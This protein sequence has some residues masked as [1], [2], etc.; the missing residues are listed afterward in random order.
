MLK[1]LFKQLKNRYLNLRYIRPNLTTS[2]SR[3]RYGNV[4]VINADGIG[5]WFVN[6]DNPTDNRLTVKINGKTVGTVKPSFPRSDINALLGKP[7]NGGFFVSWG[8]LKIDSDLLKAKRW[9]VQIVHRNKPLAGSRVLTGGVLKEIKNKLF[10]AGIIYQINREINTELVRGYIDNLEFKNRNL[11]IWGWLLPKNNKIKSLKLI[12]KKED[13]TLAEILKYGVPREDV[14]KALNIENSHLGFYGKI[15]LRKGGIFELLLEITYADNKKE[16]I[17]LGSVNILKTSLW[18]GCEESFI[19]LFKKIKPVKSKKDRLPEEVT[20]VVPVYNGFGHLKP[21]FES[22]FKNTDEPYRLVIVDDAST[23]PRVVQYLNE[24]KERHPDKVLLLRNEENKGFTHSVNRGLKRAKG[25][26]VILNSDTVVPPGWLKRLTR[27]L[28]E[29]ENVASVT[30]FTNA[31]TICSFPE[32]LHDNELPKDFHPE[33]VD[34]FFNSLEDA[35][36]R[37]ELPTGVGFCMAMGKKALKEVGLFDEQTFPRGYGEENDWCIR[38][39]KKGFKNLLAHNLFV[40]HE[41]GGSFS[42]E[43]KKKLTAKH[44]KKLLQ[45][46][47][48]YQRLVDNFIQNDPIKP[49]R[50]AAAI[51]L[52]SSKR[53]TVLILDH[54][55]GGGANLYR[56]NL[57]NE[58]LNKGKF[59]LLYTE[60]YYSYPKLEGFTDKF[61]IDAVDVDSGEL[62]EVIK[63]IKPKEVFVNELVAHSKPLELLKNLV[64]LKS[65]LG[66]KL[67]FA[68]H[69]FYAICPSYNLLNDKGIFCGVPEDLSVCKNCLKNNPFAE[70]SDDIE[71]WRKAWGEFLNS[72]DRILCFSQSSKELL[73]KAYPFLDK[74]KIKV[75]PHRLDVKLRKPKVKPNKKITTIGVIGALNYQK[76]IDVVYKLAEIIKEKQLP[77]RITIVGKPNKPVPKHLE[78]L[79]KITGPYKREE[80]PDILEKE[81]VE[82]VLFPSVWPETFSYVIEEVKSM[83]LPLISFD[84]GAQGERVKKYQKGKVVEYLN[85]SKLLGA[86]EEAK[87][88][89]S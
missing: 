6:L 38:A 41:H 53:D 78:N 25:H 31:G 48:E 10:T 15:V 1:K 18:G 46:H 70:R 83:G 37:I 66:F 89:W 61:K 71:S 11:N 39:Y 72:C 16:I 5:G 21:L 29:D 24:I 4:D 23:D 59:I 14:A 64:K 20:V 84:I 67:T 52:F 33:E 69:D 76:G 75:E 86:M 51:K 57:I 58:L 65:D 54:N 81:G 87:K 60:G 2:K 49:L 26:A 56:K 3:G 17:P 79:I 45:K 28:F 36:C 8:E 88:Q 82:A 7:V 73:L 19:E 85:L 34:S 77:Y 22:I 43:E 68:L 12:L 50:A 80:L 74:G 27:P 30:P 32:F 42:K 40:Y 47:P 44:L 55:L 63:E 9:K 13:K 35:N 62:I